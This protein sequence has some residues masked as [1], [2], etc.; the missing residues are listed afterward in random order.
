MD[1]RHFIK[2]VG[3][4]AVTAVLPFKLNAAPEPVSNSAE[5]IG[6][7]V[8]KV[9]SDENPAT[10]ADIQYVMESL[11]IRE[12]DRELSHL[13][14]RL[15]GGRRWNSDGH[16]EIEHE[17]V[18]LGPG[19]GHLLVYVGDEHRPACQ[20]DLAEIQDRMHDLFRSMPDDPHKLVTHHSVEFKWVPCRYRYDSTLSH[21]SKTSIDYKP[22]QFG[23]KGSEC[24]VYYHN[25]TAD[26]GYTKWDSWQYYT[27]LKI[28]KPGVRGTVLGV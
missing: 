20:A 26:K 16:M 15:L 23:P 9:G 18:P 4:G 28:R 7:H 11:K 8:W 24:L 3:A 2:A 17:F 1:R 22:S 14:L 25:W 12:V 27:G 5:P 13:R 6:F 19:P 10:A 21:L